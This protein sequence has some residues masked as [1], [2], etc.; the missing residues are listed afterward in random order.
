MLPR[1]HIDTH[2]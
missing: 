1:N 2:G